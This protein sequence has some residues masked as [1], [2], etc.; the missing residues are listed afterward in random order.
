MGLLKM[1]EA[2]RRFKVLWS[3]LY[4]VRVAETALPPVDAFK[5]LPYNFSYS[6]TR[7]YEFS[8]VGTRKEIGSFIIQKRR[9]LLPTECID[10]RLLYAIAYLI[11]Q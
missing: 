10:S 8:S 11:L 4:L 7:G 3:L 2:P 6:Y 1:N 9:G 5:I